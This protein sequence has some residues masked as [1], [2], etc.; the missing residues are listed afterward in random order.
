MKVSEMNFSNFSGRFR[1]SV[2][3]NLLVE[4]EEMSFENYAD[5][6]D[7]YGVYV[8]PLLYHATAVP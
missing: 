2:A 4:N 8:M 6:K 3:T 7:H 5:T 1:L